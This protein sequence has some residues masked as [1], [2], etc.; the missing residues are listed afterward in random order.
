MAS[1]TRTSR[2]KNKKMK[3]LITLSAL[4]LITAT[5]FT[6]KVSNV[7]FEQI[8]A[9]IYCYYDLEG[10]GDFSINVYYS[11]DKD[12]KW[13]GPL[14]N[15][16]GAIGDDQ[17]E[18]NNKMIIWDVLKDRDEFKGNLSFKIE[19]TSS[20][21]DQL[22]IDYGGQIYHTVQLGTQCWM[23]ENLNVG[24]KIKGNRKMKDN[25]VIE[26]YCYNDNEANC[27]DYGGLYQWSEMI[28]YATQEGV[29][30]ICPNGWHIPTDNEWKQLEMYLGMSQSEVDNVQ[31]R[32]SDE[33]Y[34]LKVT[35]GWNNDD[36]GTNIRA[37]AGGYLSRNGLFRGIGYY[38]YWWSSSERSGTNAWYQGLN[39]D[40]DQVYRNNT[41]KSLGFSVRCL[42]D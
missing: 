7:H 26:K 30:G 9:K 21:L 31:W 20:L 37:F 16:S 11:E 40:N 1:L 42:K 36:N 24:Q 8:G 4:L 27:D 2:E 3:K 35:T 5:A 41:V 34:Q 38:G 13:K 18:G 22:I 6:Q 29:Q 39:Y 12:A 23:K 33:G 19:A 10:S 28:Q 14:V 17:T 32:G 15:A 25:S